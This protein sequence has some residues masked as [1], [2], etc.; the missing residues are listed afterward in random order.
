MS[1]FVGTS[2]WMYDWNAGGS[3][4]WYAEESGLNAVELNAS[5]YRFPSR[6][7]VESWA[8]A[9][10]GRGI[11]WAV[12]VHRSITHYRMLGGASLQA[13]E[14]FRAL[15]KPLEDAG[16]LDFYLLQLPPR[17]RRTP[18]NVGRVEGFVE[19]SRVEPRMLAV[20]FR[21]PSWFTGEVVEWAGGLGFTLVS[22]D[23]PMATWI[24]SS[25]GLVYLRMHG[26]ISWYSHDYTEDELR[27]V[28]A[29]VLRLNPRAV[30]AFF[31]NDH[32]MLGNARRFKEILESMAAP[33]GGLGRGPG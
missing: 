10:L 1:V 7:Q 30:Y 19:G 27:E 13:W 29:S 20:E 18:G 4:K 2:G 14:R 16:L 32:W 9:S 17:F 22:I 6:G 25:N 5:F 24:V 12:K 31:N 3:F 21:H 33:G 15:F 11:R 23:S 28:A 8:R 26:R